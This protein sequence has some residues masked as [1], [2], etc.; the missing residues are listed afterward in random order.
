MAHSEIVKRETTLEEWIKAERD[1][2]Y[3][4]A[5]EADSQDDCCWWEGRLVQAERVLHEISIRHRG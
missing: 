5:M 1:E 4:N 3:K 2:A